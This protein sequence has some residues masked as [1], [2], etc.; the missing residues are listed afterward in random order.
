MTALEENE[1]NLFKIL[2][3]A[4]SE[5]QLTDAEKE[6]H[7]V[8]PDD[9]KNLY[10]KFN[11]FPIDE[12][13]SFQIRIL[14]LEE[15]LECTN[16][17]SGSFIP[18]DV[19]AGTGFTINAKKTDIMIFAKYHPNNTD[20]DWVGLKLS[21]NKKTGKAGGKICIMY[22]NGGIHSFAELVHS[23]ESLTEWLETCIEAY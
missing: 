21:H 12:Y 5:K 7:T 1:K 20:T 13:F 9:L 3:G 18:T 6:L 16:K 23:G 15:A 4:V 17:I 14:P 19:L 11:G 22:K 2:P 8:L 10:R